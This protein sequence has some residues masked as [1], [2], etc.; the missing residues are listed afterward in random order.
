MII[1]DLKNISKYKNLL[2]QIGDIERFILNNNL[3]EIRCGK[4]EINDNVYVNIEEYSPKDM[5][6]PEVHKKFT[7]IQIVLSGEEKIGYGG[8]CKNFDNY[9]A[10]NDIM[11]LQTECD[12]ISAKTDKFFVFFAGEV[13]APCVK[14][15]TGKVRKAVF[16]ILSI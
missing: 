11:F 16:K 8:E 1:D 5:P 7:D 6:K 15:H 3:T 13:H 4:Y 10:E 9:D 14:A 2:P 12:F